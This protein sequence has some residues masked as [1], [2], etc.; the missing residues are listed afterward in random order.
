MALSPYPN[1]FSRLVANTAEPESTQ[2]CWLWA[3][4]CDRWGYSR[5]NLY[6]DGGYRK[7]QAHIAA[8]VWLEAQPETLGEFLLAYLMVTTS[9]L[10]IDHTCVNPG[11][12]NP[13]HL[14]LVTAVENT[15]RRDA[16]RYEF[17]GQPCP[18]L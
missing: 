2:G 4:H 15:R 9:G 5:L 3:A 10:E 1:L 16:R 14:E 11:C 18:T 13:D 12:I 7:L 8:W 17:A 6:V